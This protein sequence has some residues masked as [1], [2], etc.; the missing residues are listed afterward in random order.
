MK[1]RVQVLAAVLALQLGVVATAPALAGPA[2]TALLSSYVGSYQGQGTLVGGD[3]PDPL[4]CRLTLAKGNQG[5]INYSG[6]C[7]LVRTNLSVNGT[8]AFNEGTGRYEAAMSSNVGFTGTAVGR[9]QGQEIVF[10][11]KEQQ[12][13]A[14][15]SDV[16]IGSKIFL[17]GNT[18]RVDFELEFNNSGQVLTAAV[19]FSR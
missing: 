12:K 14:G 4:R 16:R 18:I 19:P 13:D 7:T 9:Q 10:D 2:E 1:K 6:R 3:R 5:R 17:T 8:I 15:G 11:L